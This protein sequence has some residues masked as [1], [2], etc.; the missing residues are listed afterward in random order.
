MYNE[1]AAIEHDLNV[2]ADT[3]RSLGEPYEIVVV[4]DGSQDR[5]AEIVAALQWVRMLKHPY[6]RGTGAAL[7]TGIRAAQGEVIVMTD[8]DG[9]YPNQD[10]PRLLTFLGEYDMVIGARTSEQG[11]LKALRVPA[12]AFIRWLASYLT[13]VKIP[14]LNSGLRV[15]RR[16]EA[17]RFFQILPFGHSWV[18]TITM[19]YLSSGLTIKFAPIEYYPRKGRSKFHPV[20]DTY[21]YL[22]LVV[23][24]TMYFDPL[25]VL[26][27]ISLA[28]LILGLAKAFRDI[29][30]Y[31]GNVFYIP[32]STLAIVFT[33]LQLAAVGLLADLIVRRS[34]PLGSAYRE[35]N[36]PASRV[37]N[38]VPQEPDSGLDR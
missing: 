34:V 14:D 38:H 31:G 5:S 4:D 33:G 8:G 35:D 11:T 18:S 20:S 17:M 16:A 26:L 6:N 28:F 2:I 10:I 3:M 21:N 7:I 36:G 23:R 27:P 25:K 29:F 30:V 22:T 32:G 15:F 13:G 24:A 1:E 12:K 37:A 9:T 19:A